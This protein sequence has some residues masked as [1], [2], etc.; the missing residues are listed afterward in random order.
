MIEH[1]ENWQNVINNFKSILKVGG[2]LLITT[3]SKGFPYH[4]Y[5]YDFWRFE[6]DDME[7]IFTDFEIQYLES[8]LSEPGVFIKAKKLNN[9]QINLDNY[10]LYSMS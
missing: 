7:Y 2:T 3:R 10:K 8:D 6:I 9:N 5:P 1:V 4:C